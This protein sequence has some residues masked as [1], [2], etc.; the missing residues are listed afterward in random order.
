MET[1]TAVL[2]KQE[3]IDVEK[4]LEDHRRY[5]MGRRTQDIFLSV[6]ALIVLFPLMLII[7]LAVII[8]DPSSGPIFVQT[9]VGLKGKP[10]KFYKF[11][12]MCPN[13][14]EKLADVLDRNEAD[15][16]VFKIK[17]DPR[18]TRVGKFIRKTSLDELP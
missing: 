5:W 15:G 2:E 9:R 4:N 7:A 10:F 17:D 18:I 6:L 14:E 12:S 11:R 1:S 13:A 8:D 3:L 16:P